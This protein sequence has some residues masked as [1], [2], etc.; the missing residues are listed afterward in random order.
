MY[1]SFQDW[2][3]EKNLKKKVYVGIF[4]DVHSEG[5]WFNPNWHAGPISNKTHVFLVGEG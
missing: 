2:K 5:L 1:F 4:I 3:K